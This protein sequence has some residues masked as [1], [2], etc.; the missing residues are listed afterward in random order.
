MAMVD[1]VYWLPIGGP[2]AQVGWL[3]PKVGSQLV[4][5]LY[6]SFNKKFLAVQLS[7]I[8]SSETNTHINFLLYFNIHH[9][10]C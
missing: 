2:V 3:G 5:F 4:P 10:Y 7:E 8:W 9:L 1:M 6:S